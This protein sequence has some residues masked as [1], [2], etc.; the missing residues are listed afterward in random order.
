MVSGEVKAPRMELVNEELFST[1]LHSTILSICPIPQLSNGIADL[2]DY[3]NA[4]NITL[5]P[6]VVH[7]LQLSKERKQEIKAILSK[8]YQTIICLVESTKKCHIGS[9]T[10]GWTGFWIVIYM[11]LTKFLNR[12]RSLYKLAQQQIEEAQTVTRNNIYG[13]NSKEKKEALLK[14][15]RGIE[16][17]RYASR[18]KSREKCGRERILPLQIFCQRRIL[19]GYNFTKLPQRAFTAI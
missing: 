4:N 16:A 7:H 5:K 9:L 8:L 2:V 14:E 11:I 15:R 13:E 3:S 19:A 6:E 10:V 1:H 18:T 12:W 17:S